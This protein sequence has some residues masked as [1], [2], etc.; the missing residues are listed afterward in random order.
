MYT[1]QTNPKQISLLIYSI[2]FFFKFNS[3][4]NSVIKNTQ[5]NISHE[6]IPVHLD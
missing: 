6:Y 2:Y 4:M 1:E 3:F 5:G